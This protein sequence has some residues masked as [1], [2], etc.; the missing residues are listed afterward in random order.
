MN[1]HRCSENLNCRSRKK[2]SRKPWPGQSASGQIVV[3]YVLLLVVAVAVAAL[4]TKT[5]VSS[6][7]GFII[8]TWSRVVK[9]IGS[10][11][12]DDIGD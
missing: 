11:Y 1:L 8:S 5:M 12:A 10:D 6:E 7:D 4:I 3:E 2:R 9:Q